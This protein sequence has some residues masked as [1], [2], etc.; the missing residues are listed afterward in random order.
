MSIYKSVTKVKSDHKCRTGKT[1]GL[2]SPLLSVNFDYITSTA[3][4]L[5]I[6]WSFFWLQI[7]ICLLELIITRI[8]NLKNNV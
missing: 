4:E 1:P 3:L 7:V 5:G 6:K 2:S 8:P